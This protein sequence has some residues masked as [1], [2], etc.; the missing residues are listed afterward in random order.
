MPGV[1]GSQF[2]IITFLWNNFLSTSIPSSPVSIKLLFDCQFLDCVS[3]SLN[4]S[5]VF[6]IEYSVLFVPICWSSSLEFCILSIIPR[7]S[8][9]IFQY[10][11]W[12]PATVFGFKLSTWFISSFGNL[13]I[14]KSALI[15]SD[16]SMSKVLLIL[17]DLVM[18]FFWRSQLSIFPLRFRQFFC[19]LTY[20]FQ[21]PLTD[22]WI[23]SL[24]L[25]NFDI[26]SLRFSVSF[27][28]SASSNLV[29]RVRYYSHSIL[30]WG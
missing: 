17:S 24:S 13:L 19:L 23:P 28:H 11:D 20:D 5:V 2:S 22:C 10:L 25:S 7:A 21:V 27:L 14:L 9:F 1:A 26:F 3:S 16:V 18:A 29:F 15:P 12:L 4:V 30:L 8:V 6:C